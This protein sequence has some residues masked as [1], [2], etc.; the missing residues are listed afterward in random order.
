[1]ASVGDSF[2]QQLYRYISDLENIPLSI[3]RVWDDFIYKC[4][5]KHTFIRTFHE[6]PKSYSSFRLV[7]H[8]G[9]PYILNTKKEL[10]QICQSEYKV[11]ESSEIMDDD[12]LDFYLSYEVDCP[13][14]PNNFVVKI[15]EDGGL[16]NL[17]IILN[18]FDFT[19]ED[20]DAF[21]IVANEKRC[22]DILMLLLRTK[23]EMKHHQFDCSYRDLKSKYDDL[24]FHFKILKENESEAKLIK[25][26]FFYS[27]ILAIIYNLYLYL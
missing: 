25:N 19:E 26:T 15:I 23:Y 7:Y 10:W 2:E 11:T 8:K 20:L 13:D 5:D 17:Q 14:I 22:I 16:T 9:T 6:M 27:F 4:L 3:H 21:L 24:H 18:N 1:M 12:I